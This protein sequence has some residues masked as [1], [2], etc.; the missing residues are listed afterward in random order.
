MGNPW[1]NHVKQFRS[2][3]PGMSYTE[4]LHH[5]KSTYKK[6]EGA[7]IGKSLKKASK[8]VKTASKVYN[9]NKTVINALAGENAK[10]LEAADKIAGAGLA[11]KIKK[12]R[13]AAKKANKMYDN[14]QALI[15]SVAGKD[16]VAKLDKARNVS[17]IMTGGKFKFNAK[18]LK[19]G[20]NTA[21]KIG[22]VVAPLTGNPE[23]VPALMA[24]NAATGGSFKTPVSRG[25]GCKS[26]L[27]EGGRVSRIPA[28][29]EQGNLMKYAYLYSRPPPPGLRE[30]QES[31]R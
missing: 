14:N 9:K 23:L 29:K 16:N 13:K 6:V 28:N 18:K 7:G 4:A 10:Y 5:A 1:L 8:G 22:M 21:S 20:V 12:A 25:A 26:C 31:I 15:T 3:N 19:K 27:T 30:R 11:S 2:E 17:G 24:T